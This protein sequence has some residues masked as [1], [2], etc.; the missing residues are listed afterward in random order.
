MSIWILVGRDGGAHEGDAG[1]GV[2]GRGEIRSMSW[3][4]IGLLHRL[5]GWNG[6][7]MRLGGAKT[8]QIVGG[9]AEASG[10]GRSTEIGVGIK[11]DGA[12]DEYGNAG[13]TVP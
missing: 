10:G 1:A 4:G 7:M 3:L 13:A 5:G 12:F 9:G 8:P 6:R 11:V 2:D